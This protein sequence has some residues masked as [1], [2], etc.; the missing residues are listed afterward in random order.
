MIHKIVPEIIVGYLMEMKYSETDYFEISFRELRNIRSKIEE[1]DDSLYVDITFNTIRGMVNSNP[2]IFEFHDT[3]IIIFNQ[4][5]DKC[6]FL[7][8]LRNTP[9][10]YINTIEESLY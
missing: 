3:K 1:K 9:Q 10:S 8:N 7:I 6:E 4:S 5:V 2:D